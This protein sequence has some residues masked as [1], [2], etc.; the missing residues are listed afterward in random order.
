MKESHTFTINEGNRQ[1]TLLA[2]AHLAI[3]RPGWELMLSEIA[4]KFGG[5]EMYLQFKRYGVPIMDITWTC[6]ICKEERPD[7][8][9][10]VRQ[11]DVSGRYELP[12][13]VMMENIRYCNDRPA[14]VLASETFTHFRA[15]AV[16]VI[17]NQ[18][19]TTK[20]G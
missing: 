7:Q 2:L 3:E 8:F 13:G 16:V 18:P 17:S 12:A 5:L 1:A 15:G 10:S 9:I 4:K 20:G 6:H 19:S 11:H 14:C